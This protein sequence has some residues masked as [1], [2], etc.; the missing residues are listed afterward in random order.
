V[1]VNMNVP[2]TDAS[3]T[4]IATMR[5]VPI[6]GETAFLF[7]SK[8]CSFIICNRL[9]VLIGLFVSLLLILLVLFYGLFS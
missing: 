6:T 2:I 7:F 1:F 4:V 8:V 9:V 3:M 5:M